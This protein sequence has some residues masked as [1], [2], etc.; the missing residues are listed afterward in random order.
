MKSVQAA[1]R[2]MGELKNG[3]LEFDE[4]FFE[5][6]D[7]CYFLD[8]EEEIIIKSYSKIPSSKWSSSMKCKAYKI[9]EQYE[10][11]LLNLDIEFKEIE[12][13]DFTSFELETS[14]PK[15]EIINSKELKICN[16][17]LYHYNYKV[18]QQFK[19]KFS[20][21][22]NLQNL[23]QIIKGRNDKNL[24]IPTKIMG[25]LNLYINNID[26]DIESPV[27]PTIDGYNRDL[28]KFQ[29]TGI[30]FGILNKKIMLADEMGLGKSVQALAILQMANAFKAVIICPKSLK[31]KW[32]KEASYLTGLKIEIISKKTDL[33]KLDKDIYITNYENIFNYVDFFEASKEIKT[34]IFDESH[35]LKNP[36]SKRSKHCLSLAKN[37]E[38]VLLL[39]G[40][41]MLNRPSELV[42]QLDTLGVLDKFGGYTDFKELYDNPLST[43]DP[44][45]LYADL[46]KKLRSTVYIRREKS[47]ILKDLPDK[48]RSTIMVDIDLKEYN[49]VILEYRNE[50]DLKKKKQLLE[51]L[52]QIAAKGKVESIKERINVSIENN[53][54]LIVFA[55]HKSMQENLIREFPNALKIVASQSDQERF[56]SAEEFQNNPDKHIIIC[57][58]RTAYYGFDLFASSQVLFTEMDWVPEINNQAEDRAHRIGQKN[59]VNIWYLIAKNTIEERILQVNIEKSNITKQINKKVATE[60]LGIKTLSIKDEIIK[61]LDQDK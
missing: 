45:K 57:S 60:E 19:D 12:V 42:N 23:F 25:L 34:I 41:P 43:V 56:Q 10:E 17:L 37:K 59:F 9:L 6:L 14:S 33:K 8:K 40:S 32:E 15:I 47:D 3:F 50:N 53:E 16:S 46:A 36:K 1:I 54:K 22:L 24:I 39:S 13:P 20:I 29:Q 35:Y 52:K 38:H 61:Y 7:P 2:H 51:K 27:L 55:Y 26:H 18:K 49:S 5:D 31:Y 44:K 11:E 4:D 58:I 48:Q 30:L 21:D 28:M